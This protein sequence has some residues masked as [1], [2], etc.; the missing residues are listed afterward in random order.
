MIALLLAAVLLAAPT[1]DDVEARAKALKLPHPAKIAADALPGARLVPGGEATLG[2]TRL[3]GNPDL[4]A[5]MKWPR[6]GGHRLGF[7]AQL[8]VSDLAAVAPGAIA[9]RRS[10]LAVFADIGEDDD[11]Y[12]PIEGAAGPTGAKTCVIVR[13][14]RGPLSHRAVPKGVERLKSTPVKLRPTLTVPDVYIAE[15]RYDL[16][17]DQN[18]AWFRLTDELLA[19]TPGHKPKDYDPNHQVLGWPWPIQDTPLYACGKAKHRLLLQMDYD[20]DLGFAIGDG[21]VFYLSG[22]PADLRAGRFDR[23]CAEFQEG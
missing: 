6:C 22:R 17:D 12:V 4:P 8:R 11:G 5:A 3:G 1:R 20:D 10:T 13:E 23:L 9:S 7:L 14:L 2:G 16:K 15:K 18:D 19:G 21:G